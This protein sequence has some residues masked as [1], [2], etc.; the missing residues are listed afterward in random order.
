MST[1][2]IPKKNAVAGVFLSNNYAVYI[3][4]GVYQIG[5]LQARSCIV[6]GTSVSGGRL[7]RT[8]S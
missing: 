4:L 7:A 2:L 1:P 3:A 6:A 8:A 5:E